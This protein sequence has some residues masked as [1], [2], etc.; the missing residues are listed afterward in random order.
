MA[1]K[2]R[3]I[4]QEGEEEFVNLQP[5]WWR[6][7]YRMAPVYAAISVLLFGFA[8]K[9]LDN[10]QQV[11]ILVG[12]VAVLAAVVVRARYGRG[13]R[14]DPAMQTFMYVVLVVYFGLI[15]A[16]RFN[17]WP[18]SWSVTALV[19]AFV[20]L[21]L[22]WWFDRRNLRA[23]EVEAELARWPALV[24]KIGLKGVRR[25]AGRITETGKRI[26]LSWNPGTTTL[27]NVQSHARGLE[28]ITG[29]KHKRI[30][31]IPVTDDDG[32]VETNM[33][34][35]EENKSA[36]GRKASVPFDHP[37]M[38]TVYDR[39]YIGP[40]ENGEDY[41][42]VWYDKKWGG[43]HTLA[44]G[45]T[46][47]GK[48]G[49]YDLIIA[50]SILCRDL[51]KWGCDPKGG[52]TML[53]WAPTFDWFT[54][55]EKG[56][57]AMLTAVKEI[58]T[59]RAAYAASKGW[60][61]W[62]ASPKNPLLLVVID[63]CAEVFGMFS[64][65]VELANSIARMGRAAGVLLLLATQYPT[66]EAI[67]SSQLTKNIGRRFCFS[68][69]DHLAQRVILPGSSD[70]VDATSIP[71][72]PKYA[73]TF[74]TSEGG[75][76]NTLS[77][78]VRFVSEEKIRELV[79][80]VGDA[81][82]KLDRMSIAAALRATEKFGENSYEARK[83]WLVEDL[84]DL[85]DDD[86]EDEEA[87]YDPE[88][89]EEAAA[90][91]P[92]GRGAAPDP[93]NV[94]RVTFGDSPAPPPPEEQEEVLEEPTVNITIAELAD[95]IPEDERQKLIAEYLVGQQ[96]EDVTRNEALARLDAALDAAG[97]EGIGAGR[98]VKIVGRQKTWVYDELERLTLEQKVVP[99]E[100][101][102]RYRRPPGQVP[103]SSGDD[104][105]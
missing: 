101:P 9:L 34:D 93:D 48:S 19:V 59:D 23:Q 36:P 50:D 21:G 41:E 35:I 63:E 78:R 104:A 54:T 86:E 100:S 13:K 99:A 94:R 28:S 79:V 85:T 56:C 31:F 37:R 57:E 96:E 12:A 65:M 55:T 80:M 27:E 64:G 29:I 76:I 102:G 44:A 71:V 51:V 89:D 40:L 14:R 25:S 90:P 3:R 5:W 58:L 15:L 95:S 47:S 72:G 68:V 105:S 16:I 52:M 22:F 4:R 43:K 98:L 1:K 17:A 69:L 92:E 20:V 81:T 39:N 42:V 33:I 53:G 49:L 91:G 77:G 60:K 2:Q 11:V 30:R 75:V 88:D 70:T 103:G 10:T 73:G 8:L 97:Q 38:Q 32:D 62:R 7:R 67:S 26:R 82:S 46:G 87:G 84:P 24:E 18:I 74:F 6:T 66:N 61:V 45:Q 83:I